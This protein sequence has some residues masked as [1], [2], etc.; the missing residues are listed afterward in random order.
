MERVA[1]AGLAVS[2]F[3][4]PPPL[5]TSPIGWNP[6]SGDSWV[7]TWLGDMNR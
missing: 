3:V 2:T 1:L 7:A 6:R 5:G 4:A